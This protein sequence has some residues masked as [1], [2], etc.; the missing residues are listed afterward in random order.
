MIGRIATRIVNEVQGRQPRGLRHH[1]E[2]A[3]YDRM[4]IGD[5]SAI[6]RAIA[7]CEGT[8]ELSNLSRPEDFDERGLFLVQDS[9]LRSRVLPLFSFD[10]HS[11][12]QRP[13]RAWHYLPY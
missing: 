4:G 8:D 5:L 6:E 7:E 13:E 1:V 3:G 11:T 2:A 12:E 10:P 9:E